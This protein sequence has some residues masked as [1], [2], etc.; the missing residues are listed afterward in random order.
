MTQA[1]FSTEINA[2][3]EVIWKILMDEVENNH[4]YSQK[5][6]DVK[7]IERFHDGVLRVVSVRDADVRERVIFDYA[8]REV[9]STLVGHP[10]LAGNIIKK[11]VPVNSVTDKPPYNV[12]CTIEWQSNDA[13][14]DKMI[15]RNVESFIVNGLK[16]VK[17]KAEENKN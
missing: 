6:L 5:V 1:A 16:L 9:N 17:A 4:L 12:Q 7:I 15:R 14:V 2:D 3:F 13:N 8:Q 10:H 11:I